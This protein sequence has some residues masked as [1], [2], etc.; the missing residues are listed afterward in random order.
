[1]SLGREC[2]TRWGGKSKKSH[3]LSSIPESFR[4]SQYDHLYEASNRASMPCSRDG[5]ASSRASRENS[6]TFATVT[7]PRAP[8]S[9]EISGL[10]WFKD[11]YAV[12]FKML[13]LRSL[14]ELIAAQIHVR[15]CK[16]FVVYA[17]ST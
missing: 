2:T 9:G 10:F 15:T 4:N 16:E 12:K 11:Y 7:L 1:M 14:F 17:R 3:I 13:V 8:E 6:I 5:D